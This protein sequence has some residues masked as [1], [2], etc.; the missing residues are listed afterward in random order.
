[1]AWYHDRCEA[2][3]V[4]HHEKVMPHSFRIGGATALFSQ[5]VTAEEIR[6]MGRWSSDIHR[7]YVRACFERCCFWSKAAGS[8]SVTDV[9]GASFDEADEEYY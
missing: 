7:L 4:P 1:M 6:T 2:A 9:A 5:G 3:G 8:A